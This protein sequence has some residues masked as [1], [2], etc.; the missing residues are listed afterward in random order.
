MDLWQVPRAMNRMMYDAMRD[1]DRF[2]RSLFPYWRDADHSVLHVANEVQKV[3]VV[4]VSVALRN[5]HRSS[6]DGRRRQE[7]RGLARRVAVSTR[8]AERA[9][10]GSRAH[11]RG[12]A[13][14]QDREQLHAQVGT[15]V[16]G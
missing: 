7:V 6:L 13:G 12:Q 16:F 14:A 1:F 9:P 4:C 5:H 15:A 2:E 3:R 8:G 10:G 11:H